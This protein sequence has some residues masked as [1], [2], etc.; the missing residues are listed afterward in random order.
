MQKRQHIGK[1]THHRLDKA[2]GVGPRASRP[3]RSPL[4]PNVMRLRGC[5]RLLS[6]RNLS[7]GT[8]RPQG[9]QARIHSLIQEYS[10]GF[11]CGP[12]AGSGAQQ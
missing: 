6:T 7:C 5:R 11:Y 8:F 1:G 2:H 3:R 9:R 10:Q 12:D 4:V